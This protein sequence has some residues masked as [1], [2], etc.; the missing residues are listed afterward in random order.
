MSIISLSSGKS[1]VV[2][3]SIGENLVPSIRDEEQKFLGKM[4]FYSGKS[5]ETFEYIKKIFEEALGNIEKCA[6]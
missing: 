4:L 5:E 1:L 3:F 6:I 2:S